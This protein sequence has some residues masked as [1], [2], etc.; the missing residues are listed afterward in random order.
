MYTS[1]KFTG[2]HY[3]KHHKQYKNFHSSYF[4]PAAARTLIISLS[5][6]ITTQLFYSKIPNRYLGKIR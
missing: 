3:E 1:K 4:S 6:F 2:E 5:I